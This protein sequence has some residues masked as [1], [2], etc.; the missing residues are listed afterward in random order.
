LGNAKRNRANFNGSAYL[1]WS[2]S[3]NLGKGIYYFKDSIIPKKLVQG[4]E[5][6]MI[7]MEIKDNRNQL[8]YSKCFKHGENKYYKFD[9][10]FGSTDLEI[11]QRSSENT[12]I[13]LDIHQNS[14]LARM[15]KNL[16][17]I[18]LS[19]IPKKLC[20]PTE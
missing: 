20:P 9:Y 12:H 2:G 16:F 4:L 5:K 1:D 3:V 10:A 6:P 19:V 11:Y 14:S 13:S 15:M 18:E 17:T 7:N 8:L